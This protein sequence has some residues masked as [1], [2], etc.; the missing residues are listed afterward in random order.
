MAI[1]CVIQ[2]NSCFIPVPHNDAHVFTSRVTLKQT[3]TEIDIKF[4]Y[5]IL[6]AVSIQRFTLINI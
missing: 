6:Y 5:R 3:V 2:F 4:L 1:F